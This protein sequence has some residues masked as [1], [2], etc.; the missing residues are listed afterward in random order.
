MDRIPLA[1]LLQPCSDENRTG[2]NL[3]YDARFIEMCDQA[4]PSREVEFGNT[5]VAAEEPDWRSLLQSS[6][7]LCHET[8]DLRAGVYLVEA[9]T[10][11]QAFQGLADGLKLLNAWV[12]DF[13]TELHPQLDPSDDLDP[14]VRLGA[15]NRLCH[16][17]YLLAGISDLVLAEEPTLG[18]VTLRQIKRSVASPEENARSLTKAEIEAIFC[19]APVEELRACGDIVFE[20]IEQVEHL[21]EQLDEL[22]G[23]GQWDAAPL[24][25][26]LRECSGAIENAYGHRAGAVHIPTSPETQSTPSKV[27]DALNS[28]SSDATSTSRPRLNAN[29]LTIETRAEA[30]EV[31]DRLC[32][33]F[34]THE[35][36]S[37]V[38]LLLQRAKRL[39][40][41]SFV[42]I[43]RELAPNGLDQAMQSIGGIP[44]GE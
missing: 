37:P 42:D 40:P 24:M 39:I 16:T 21:S 34:K 18:R 35:P 1:T 20:C 11:L 29:Q 36:A 43:L 2:N 19:A 25:T 30:I 7:N 8:R 10:R 33:Y 6:L 31:I 22:I 27:S 13:W 17:N 23:K 28:S 14:A 15:L 41:M 12:T 38:P 32:A 9:L 3:E 26:M 44:D 4:E 5:L